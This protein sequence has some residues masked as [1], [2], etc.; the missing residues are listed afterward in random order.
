VSANDLETT[1]RQF[2]SDYPVILVMCDLA[3]TSAFF[4]F[5][6]AAI[7]TDNVDA[8]LRRGPDSEGITPHWPT[9]TDLLPDAAPC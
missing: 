1:L 8:L 4:E 9:R 7:C 5:D 2:E 3:E 6:R